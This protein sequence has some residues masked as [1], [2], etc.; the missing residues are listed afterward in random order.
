[1]SAFSSIHVTGLDKNVGTVHWRFADRT[2]KQVVLE[3]VDGKA[4]FYDNPIGVLTNSPG[5][6]WHLTNL[7]NYMTLVPG[8]ADG[9]AWSSLASSFPVKAASGGSGMYGLPGDPT[10]Q[11]RFVRTAV[12]KATAPV[13]ENG[14]AAMLQSFK[15]LEAMVVPLGVVVDVNANPEKTTDMI[16]S[17]QFTTVSDIDALKLYYR[18]MDNSKIRCI[19]LSAID[20]GKVKYVSAPLDEKKEEVEII[21]I[22]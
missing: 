4:N 3:I 16:T 11:S 7:S 1:M 6:Q 14:L 20:F 21:K 5:F 2:G 18:T 12:Y 19:D 9:R 17:T 13:P 10:S 15:I 8:N 22:K